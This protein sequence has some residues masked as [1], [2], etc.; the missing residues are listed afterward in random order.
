MNKLNLIDWEILNRVY[1]C[2]YE[3]VDNYRVIVVTENGILKRITVVDEN[4][5]ELFSIDNNLNIETRGEKLKE[6]I[7]KCFTDNGIH[8]S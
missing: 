6:D 4:E 8:A 5:E 2:L 1:Q 3:K 7:A